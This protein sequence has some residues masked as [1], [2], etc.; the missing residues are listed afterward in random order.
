[1]DMTYHNVFFYSDLAT[2][3]LQ[4]ALHPKLCTL[5]PAQT[6]H[7]S[8]LHTSPPTRKPRHSTMGHSSFRVERLYA[9]TDMVGVIATMTIV[10]LILVGVLQ[11]ITI[12]ST[13]VVTILIITFV[14]N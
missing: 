2:R 4:P 12:T 1:M 10:F 7:P 8:F 13:V 6:S 3:A 14:I 11:L 5:N 9:V